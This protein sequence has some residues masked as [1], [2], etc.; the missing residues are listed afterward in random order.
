MKMTDLEKSMVNRPDKGA[1]NAK[2]IGTQ[3]EAITIRTGADVLELGCGIGDVAA[4]LA[5]ERG[6]RVVATDADPEQIG[7]ARQRH[8]GT[9]GLDLEVADAARLRFAPESFDVVVSQNV[10][11]HVP[12]WREAVR[13]ISRVLRPGGYLLWLDLTLP[14]PLRL[15]LSPLTSWAGVYTAREVR[16]AFR[17]ADLVER[18][19][20]RLIGGLRHELMLEKATAAEAA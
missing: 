7:L 3:L 19:S 10:F 6:F 16:E 8:G 20:R 4:F 11:H 9:P 13:E 5:T 18:Q 17:A 14:S 1:A 15:L 12:E 2:R